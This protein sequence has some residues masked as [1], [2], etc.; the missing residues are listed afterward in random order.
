MMINFVKEGQPVPNKE[1]TTKSILDE[2]KEW[3]VTVDL[4]KKLVFPNVIQTTLRPDIVLSSMISK[5]IV[6]IE[7]TVPWET[8]CDEAHERKKAKYLQL[9]E[10]CKAKGWKC[11]LF[12]VEIG[13]RQ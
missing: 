13:P 2:A 7:L 11:W 4:K 8:R 5:A 9:Q 1:K 12:P 10:D 6:M 3:E